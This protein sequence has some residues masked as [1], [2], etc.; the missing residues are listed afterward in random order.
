MT[1]KP[2]YS[3]PP[4]HLGYRWRSAS[5]SWFGGVAATGQFCLLLVTRVHFFMID[6]IPGEMAGHLSGRLKASFARRL[7]ALFPDMTGCEIETLSAQSA[8]LVWPRLDLAGLLF[9]AASVSPSIR[10]SRPG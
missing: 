8:A 1:G 7:G 4:L 9:A 2:S 3:D 10:M 6:C 5:P